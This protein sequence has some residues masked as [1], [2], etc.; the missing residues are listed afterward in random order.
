M[1]GNVLEW[2]ADRYGETY[3][4]TGPERNPE[5]PESGSSRVCRGG[6]WARGRGDLRSAFR[7]DYPSDERRND[8]GFRCVSP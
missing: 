7:Y 5:G 8:L 4:G 2:C 6:S 3:Y 1:A